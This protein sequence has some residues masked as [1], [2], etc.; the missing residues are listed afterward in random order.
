MKDIQ[1]LAFDIAPEDA[2]YVWDTSH[3]DPIF[4]KTDEQGQWWVMKVGEA[5]WRKS[6]S[7]QYWYNKGKLVSLYED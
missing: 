6:C 5:H 4:Y 1:Q 2:M 3:H 7:G